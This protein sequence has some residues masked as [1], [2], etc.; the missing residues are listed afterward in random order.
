MLS[1]KNSSR[2][3]TRRTTKVSKNKLNIYRKGLYLKIIST[4]TIL[5]FSSIT[6]KQFKLIYII[7][8]TI[9]LLSM[10]FKNTWTIVFRHGGNN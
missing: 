10:K 7:D 6:S 9:R 4:K 8:S 3:A 1:T 5:A 2:H